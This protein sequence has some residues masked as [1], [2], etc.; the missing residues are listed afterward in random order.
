MIDGKLYI[1]VLTENY[2]R[3]ELKGDAFNGMDDVFHGADEF[4]WR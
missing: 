3:G 2:P 1:F 4:N